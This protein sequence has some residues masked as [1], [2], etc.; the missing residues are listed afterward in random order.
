MWVERDPDATIGTL[1]TDIMLDLYGP[2]SPAQLKTFHYTRGDTPCHAPRPRETQPHPTIDH[3]TRHRL[4][5]TL[6]PNDKLDEI[7]SIPRPVIV[8]FVPHLSVIRGAHVRGISHRLG[9]FPGE[10]HPNKDQQIDP[11]P[12][13]GPAQIFITIPEISVPPHPPRQACTTTMDLPGDLPTLKK[14]LSTITGVPPELMRLRYGTRE[15]TANRTLSQQ[16]ILK[17]VTLSLTIGSLRGGADTSLGG[18][19]SEDAMEDDTEDPALPGLPTSTP[20][21]LTPPP[22][23]HSNEMQISI[24]EWIHRIRMTSPLVHDLKTIQVFMQ[25]LS[26]MKDQATAAILAAMDEGDDNLV[27]DTL[28]IQRVQERFPD[29]FQNFLERNDTAFPTDDPQWLILLNTFKDLVAVIGRHVEHGINPAR[30]S[31]LLL[32]ANGNPRAPPASRVKP[33]TSETFTLSNLN[34]LSSAPLI[35]ALSALGLQP[36]S[37][38]HWNRDITFRPSSQLDSRMGTGSATISLLRTTASDQTMYD[39]YVTRTRTL[40]IEGQDGN[41]TWHLHRAD[42]KAEIEED[43]L[44]LEPPSPSAKRDF[45]FAM[46]MYRAVGHTESDFLDNISSTLARRVFGKWQNSTPKP[47]THAWPTSWRRKGREGQA[48]YALEHIVEDK[49]SKASSGTS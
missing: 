35:K 20:Q 13:I 38:G 7:T 37:T 9:P 12:R 36:G 48:S 33:M 2:L 1:T 22:R 26:L 32:K 45:Q 15:V 39:L 8:I 3:P 42:G 27:T 28:R 23:A 19:S 14:N 40:D 4:N 34:I 43:S 41:P 17:D 16:N 29:N 49:D 11:R 24:D 31:R 25:A 47:G 46:A 30:K 10:T 44:I 5:G 6:R 18:G 21:P